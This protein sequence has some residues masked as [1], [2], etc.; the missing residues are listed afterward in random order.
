VVAALGRLDVDEVQ[1]AAITAEEE[2]VDQGMITADIHHPPDRALAE[3]ALEHLELRREVRD[4]ALKDSTSAQPGFGMK[5][6]WALSPPQP[7]RRRA[8][9]RQP[10][11][12]LGSLQADL[13]GVAP[14]ECRQLDLGR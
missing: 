3:E 12:M 5:E 14:G 8:Q 4:H 7:T 1:I 10:H 2:Q 6:P 11:Q 13:G 9:I